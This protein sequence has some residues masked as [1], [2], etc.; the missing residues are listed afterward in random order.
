MCSY[1]MGIQDIH[2]KQQI[3]MPGAKSRY[4]SL[5]TL[6]HSGFCSDLINSFQA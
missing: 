4:V 2:G 5:S 6:F 3:N 1:N